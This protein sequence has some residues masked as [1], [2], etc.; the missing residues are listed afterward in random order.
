LVMLFVAR[1]QLRV[2]LDALRAMSWSALPLVAGLFV[3]VQALE[4]AGAL[5]F[6]VDG[7]H[8]AAEWPPLAGLSAVA[9]GFGV[10]ANAMNNLPM[11]LIGAGAV[12][13]AHS[14]LTMHAAVLLGINLGPN[15][16]VTGSLATILWLIA[17]R[18]EKIAISGWQFFRV[19]LIV[20][21]PAL[22]L[23]VLALTAHY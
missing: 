10:L 6:S 21:P 3:L 7:L 14:S 8:R 23:A 1:T 22:L 5:V 12:K 15:L 13:A 19:G 20:M 4:K 2:M 18:R 11:G 17:L 16:S 9:V